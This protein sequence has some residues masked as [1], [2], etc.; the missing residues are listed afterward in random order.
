LRRFRPHV[1]QVHESDGALVALLS[2]IIGAT[3][4]PQPLLISLLQVSYIE[5]MRAVRPLT[6]RG[7]VLGRPGLDER[8]FRLFKAPVQ[9]LFGS[10]SAWLAD[11]VLAP[12]RVTANEISRDYRVTSVGVVPNVTG[13]LSW[14]RAADV[15]R[16]GLGEN[17]LFVGRLRLRKGVEV[18]LAAIDTLRR[19]YPTVRL[20]IVGD[21][22]QRRTLELMVKRLDLV[23][24]VEFL[25]RQA[26]EEVRRL[27]AESRALVVPSIYEG[28]PLVI[29]EA[30]EQG[31]PVVASAVSGIPEVVI[32]GETGWLVHPE[33]PQQLSAAL[34]EVASDGQEAARRGEAGQQRVAALY[35]P[36]NAA[37]LWE[38]EVVPLIRP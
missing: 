5:E 34:R 24:E 29:L 19:E 28:M 16:N 35:R 33:D 14:D 12:S 3:V 13:G 36:A 2:R 18:L 11:L 15:R 1:V 17:L 23:D 9:V 22:E 4:R 21:G 10:L 6:Y 37:M 32:D 26:P 31:V 38:Q 8:R 30:M 7:E 27:L 25:G 20:R